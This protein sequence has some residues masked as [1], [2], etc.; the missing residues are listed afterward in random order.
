ME[1][2]EKGGGWIG[3]TKGDWVGGGVKGRFAAGFFFG[4]RVERCAD[5]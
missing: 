2:V 3:R 5:L 1:E 4:R